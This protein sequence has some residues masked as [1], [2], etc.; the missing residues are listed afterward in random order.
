MVEEI[1]SAVTQLFQIMN[2]QLF[3]IVRVGKMY[4]TV[5]GAYPYTVPYPIIQCTVDL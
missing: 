3:L 1:I 2:I 5:F 4:Q